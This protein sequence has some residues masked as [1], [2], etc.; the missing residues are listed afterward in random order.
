M[1]MIGGSLTKWTQ[2][3]T[4]LDAMDGIPFTFN[5]DLTGQTTGSTNSVNAAISS[6]NNN[7]YGNWQMQ[8]NSTGTNAGK[9]TVVGM[10][11]CS[12][13]GCAL[14]TFTSPVVVTGTNFNTQ[15][16]SGW[17]NSFGGSLNIPNTGSAHVKADAVSY[18]SQSNVVPGSASEP[19]TLY[20]LSN[21]PDATS[22][23][24]A[25]SYS[26][27]SGSSPYNTA[28]KSQ[29]FSASSAA[30]TVTYTF[31]A[32]G[33]VS[34]STAMTITNSKF[35]NNSNNKMFSNGMQTGML[36]D[37]T[38][39]GTTGF[40]TCSQGVCQPNNPTAYYTW[41]TGTNQWNQSMWLTKT[42]NSSVV[43]FD[44]PQNISYTVPTGSTYGT[45]AGKTIVLQFDGFGNLQGIP[46]IC[47]SPV[48]NSQVDCTTSNSRWVTQF[49]IPDGATMTLPASGSTAAIP[50]IVKA[51]NGEERL[52]N[53]GSGATTAACSGMS[54]ATQTLP[55]AT[56]LHNMALSTDSFYIGTKPTP[57]SSVPKII[58]GVA[59]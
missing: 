11:S 41:S 47:V 3:R 25:N 39:T 1:S 28:T 21:C 24:A 46:S 30:N 12:N 55:D 43:A 29:W 40:A 6:N 4:T 5:G 15:A 23:T 35:L 32:S 20:C 27:G 19:T 7:G 26:S 54:I 2:N 49:S 44:P 52:T 59:Q 50:L 56:Q 8:W 53:L 42:S 33:L 36:F 22:I 17:S 57:S 34:G 37:A 18:Y 58:D 48:D 51:L 31:G 45:W 9:F 10:Q 13:N 16:I 38:A 14:T